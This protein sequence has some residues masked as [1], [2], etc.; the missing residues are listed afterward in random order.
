MVDQSEL[1]FRLLCKKYG[2]QLAYTPMINSK[3]F[4]VSEEYRKTKFQ[5]TKEIDL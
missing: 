5:T 4:L 2:A 1:A 3:I